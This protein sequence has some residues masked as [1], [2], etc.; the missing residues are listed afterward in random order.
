MKKKRQDPLEPKVYLSS[1]SHPDYR[2]LDY[3][4]LFSQLYPGFPDIEPPQKDSILEYYRKQIDYVE[5][6]RKGW[7]RPPDRPPSFSEEADRYVIDAVK[8]YGVDALRLSAENEEIVREKRTRDLH[9]EGLEITDQLGAEVCAVIRYWKKQVSIGGME[10]RRRAAKRIKEVA[11]ALTPE[12]RGKRKEIPILSDPDVIKS[13][14]YKELFR[15]YHIR[16]TLRAPGRNWSEKV[17]AAS[18]NFEMPVH[19]IRWL[20]GLDDEDKPDR[21][22][23]TVKEMARANSSAF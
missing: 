10:A 5:K 12:T 7:E 22:P 18:M 2:R 20:W 11:R 15:L 16:Y 17:K 1:K 21:Q 3:E 19:Q 23:F 8:E 13:I 14:Y 6:I 4:Y 9:V